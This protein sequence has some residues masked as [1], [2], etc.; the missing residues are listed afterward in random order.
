MDLIELAR[1]I[2]QHHFGIN[3]NGVSRC[4]VCEETPWPCQPARLASLTLEVE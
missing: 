3:I 2:V 4:S 1:W